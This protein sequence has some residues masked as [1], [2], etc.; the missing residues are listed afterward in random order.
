MDL[1]LDHGGARNPRMNRLASPPRVTADIGV[2]VRDFASSTMNLKRVTPFGTV[3]SAYTRG[4]DTRATRVT[5]SSQL[6]P[7]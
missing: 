4:D 6:R 5:W 7:H 2:G 3:K 1:A